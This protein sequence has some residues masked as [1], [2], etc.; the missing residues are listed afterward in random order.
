MVNVL[1]A[2][3]LSAPLFGLLHAAVFPSIGGKVSVSARSFVISMVSRIISENSSFADMDEGFKNDVVV[4]VLGMLSSIVMGRKVGVLQSGL[5]AS[6]IDA[7]S[8]RIVKQI[9]GSDP[10]LFAA[11]N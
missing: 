1:T 7:M 9:M 10:V 3:D 8:Y 4:T 11:G 2:S 6:S 5:S